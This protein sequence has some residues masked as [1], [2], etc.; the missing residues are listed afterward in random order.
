MIISSLLSQP[1]IAAVCFIAVVNCVLRD[2]E[3]WVRQLRAVCIH[4][5]PS[6]VF[7]DIPS[8]QDDGGIVMA[9]HTDKGILAT[10]CC[11]VVMVLCFSCFP[12]FNTRLRGVN[13]PPHV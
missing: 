6:V 8:S 5:F 7:K 11:D 2:M 3:D 10:I 12:F 13:R 1:T 9:T 4:R